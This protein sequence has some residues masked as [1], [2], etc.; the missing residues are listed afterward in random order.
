[1]NNKKCVRP[2]R[3]DENKENIET[4]NKK[5][6][7]PLKLLFSFALSVILV[8]AIAS[9]FNLVDFAAIGGTIFM[10]F[11]IICLYA[12]YVF[13]DVPPAWMG[14]LVSFSK[15]IGF[16]D[17][18]WKF[19]LKPFQ[20][21]AI[22]FRGPQTHNYDD[23]K[24]STRPGKQMQ[25][26]SGEEEECVRTMEVTIDSTVYF[27]FP[28]NDALMNTLRYIGEIVKEA[29]DLTT[30]VAKIIE[31][32]VLSRIIALAGDRTWQQCYWAKEDFQKEINKTLKE[33]ESVIKRLCLKR[34][35]VVIT[36][37]E[38]PPEFMQALDDMETARV[39]KVAAIINASAEAVS[40]T[41]KRAAIRATGIDIQ[42]LLTMGEMADGQATKIFVP[43][44]DFS[45]TLQK[46]LKSGK[47][48][49][50]DEKV[51]EAIRKKIVE[52]LKESGVPEKAILDLEEVF[53]EHLDKLDK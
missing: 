17:S 46:A 39:K 25:I 16:V 37:V 29:S 45:E 8:V 21:I 53:K 18:G 41:I 6:F 5:S 9:A 42:A 22:F 20:Y 7:S 32:E 19:P 52:S 50:G 49:L 3:E 35:K 14:V 38:L 48:S 13:T 26:I 51:D 36:N 23:V 28:E 27:E 2:I 4:E 11:L 15:P 1:M 34:F 31:D 30:K 47:T 44:S 43:F 33:E 10:L 40:L 24:V 12:W